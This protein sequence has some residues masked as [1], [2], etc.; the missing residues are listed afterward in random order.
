[1]Q[2]GMGCKRGRWRGLCCRQFLPAP[3][4]CPSFLA[5]SRAQG[6]PATCMTQTVVLCPPPLLWFS[7]M[8]VAKLTPPTIFKPSHDITYANKMPSFEF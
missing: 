2:T 1:M 8:T 3:R 7:G 6:S 5:H 4:P